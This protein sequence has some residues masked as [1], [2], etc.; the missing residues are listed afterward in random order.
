M[1]L[2]PP[3]G[4]PPEPSEAPEIGIVL[5]TIQHGRQQVMDILGA[6]DEP[7]VYLRPE[8]GGLEWTVPLSGLWRLVEPRAA[9]RV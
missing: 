4:Q 9:R 2:Q 6:P 5:D 1:T 8:H 3:T 7:T